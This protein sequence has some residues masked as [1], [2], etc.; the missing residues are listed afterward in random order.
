MPC[1]FSF[2]PKEVNGATVFPAQEPAAL[3]A[4]LEE[5]AGEF[6]AWCV[7]GAV[8]YYREGIADE[9]PAVL[10]ATASFFT[11]EDPV[12]QFFEQAPIRYTG[13][14]SDGV[15]LK[16]LA[17]LWGEEGLG[18]VTARVMGRMLRGRSDNCRYSGEYINCD[19]GAIGGKAKAR[20]VRGWRL[21]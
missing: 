16:D 21:A 15:S 14:Q 12:V 10:E 6:L 7:Q 5:N 20:G 18:Q 13:H 19:S 8:R 3:D 9:P 11:Q 4:V 17:R 2:D 1:R